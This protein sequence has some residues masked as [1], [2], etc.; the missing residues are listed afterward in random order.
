MDAKSDASI[1]SISWI[2]PPSLVDRARPGPAVFYPGPI[3]R[4]RRSAGHS[5]RGSQ[6][7]AD[8]PRGSKGE[9]ATTDANVR[10]AV[11]PQPGQGAE[12]GFEGDRS[13]GHRP[14]SESLR[15]GDF[16]TVCPPSLPSDSDEAPSRPSPPA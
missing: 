9:R 15:D 14:P 3:F 5:E 12:T 16:D 6:R 10:Q 7:S 13:R 4:K 11:A 8:E 1:Q 2:T